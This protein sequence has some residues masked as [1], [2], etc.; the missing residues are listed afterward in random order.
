MSSSTPSKHK[1]EFPFP[2][3]LPLKKTSETMVN[4]EGRDE[5]GSDYAQTLISTPDSSLQRVLFPDFSQWDA[6]QSLPSPAGIR[7]GHFEITDRIG[8]GGMGSV[9]LATDLHLQ[10]YVALKILSPSQAM[11]GT[12]V[13]RF[14]NEARAAA[15]LDY[16]GISRVFYYGEDKGFHFIAFEYVTGI[17]I[18]EMIHARGPL[19][20]REVLNYVLQLAHALKH[21]SAAGVVH[22][23]IKPS[24]IIVGPSGRAKLVDLGLARKE[25]TET[26]DELTVA[27]TTL[28]TFDYISPEQAQDPRN[29]DIRSD[30]YS[31]GC[32]V[33]HMLTGEA[34]YPDGTLAQKLLE[35]QHEFVP[36][37]SIKNRK[38]SARF[39]AITQKMMASDPARR[40]QTPEA[41]IRDLLEVAEFEGLQ[42]L[43]PEGLVWSGNQRRFGREWLIRHAS[44]IS[45]TLV[46][47]AIVFSLD[48]FAGQPE[49]EDPLKAKGPELASQGSPIGSD[50]TE[51]NQTSAADNP[52]GDFE[53]LPK[54]P[55]E[56]PEHFQGALPAS[57]DPSP[58]E[59]ILDP[60]RPFEER[61]DP[62]N[63]FP[64]LTSSEA[65]QG[66]VIPMAPVTPLP[67]FPE[68]KPEEKAPVKADPPVVVGVKDFP[69]LMRSSSG[70]QSVYQTLEAA[71]AEAR[72]GSEIELRYNGRRERSE[73][74]IVINGDL[75]IRAA[76]GF[77]PLI[78]FESSENPDPNDARMITLQ[79]GSLE[80]EGVEIEFVIR[81]S[82]RDVSKDEWV[83]F[84]LPEA[85][86][87]QLK[88]VVL[89]IRNSARH[90]P[91][92]FLLA[93]KGTD[94][95]RMKMKQ[96][97]P[98]GI[99]EGVIPFEVEIS[100]SLIRGEADGILLEN[101]RPGQ[102]R[103][104]ET[105]FLLENSLLANR[106][107]SDMPDEYSD[108]QL[109]LS[110]V[111]CLTGNSPF[112]IETGKIPR[113]ILPIEIASE[114]SLY[115]LP[116]IGLAPFVSMSGETN[117]TD[118]SESLA[119]SGVH[120]WYRGFQ[121]FRTI[122]DSLGFSS[123]ED[124]DFE[125]WREYWTL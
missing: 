96:M 20:P 109:S 25:S 88:N 89:T 7:L 47:L 40:H 81:H 101:I 36:D 32:T 76:A 11:G 95:D 103:A 59:N 91:A 33:Y 68:N 8:T 50:T 114:N 106:G 16:D 74:P 65:P 84:S 5:A 112:R 83:L 28:G 49:S 75:T 53:P 77:H 4:P 104:S 66:F 12:S 54:P 27:G 29:V 56:L 116:S 72:D 85:E 92:A 90:Q 39:A 79:A 48:Y 123:L 124:L 67:V 6:E 19:P 46:L 9:F 115:Y 125:S 119:W 38:V 110:H 13:Q 22:R 105:M 61:Y 60:S 10:R 70:Q 3:T 78:S 51:A 80:L 14:M 43:T 87:L 113:E 21:T 15:R 86:K 69:V 73:K 44:W 55:V 31:L 71:C 111:T 1:G 93:G 24:N 52:S 118:F 42:G 63:L 117:A 30:I 94:L 17:N 18:R 2:G 102:I 58:S 57:S 26:M 100:N 23:D 99:T 122:N 41:L 98:V 82:L 37:P 107:S 64:P 62:L 120:N 121:K 34:P 97:P 108:I 35:H 45:A